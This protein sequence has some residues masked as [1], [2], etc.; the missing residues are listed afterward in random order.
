L[1]ANG[2]FIVDASASK[3]KIKAKVLSEKGMTLKLEVPENGYT[4]TTPNGKTVSLKAGI[5]T[6]ETAPFDVIYIE[7]M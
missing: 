3:G 6:I 4:I 7:S 5:Y 2:A 1:R